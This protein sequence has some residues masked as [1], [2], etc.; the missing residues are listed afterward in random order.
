[1]ENVRHWSGS[2]AMDILLFFSVAESWEK[3]IVVSALSSLIKR[4]FPA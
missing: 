3:H 4:Q 2:W 1:M